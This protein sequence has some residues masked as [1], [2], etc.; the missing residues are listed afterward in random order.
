MNLLQKINFHLTKLVKMSWFN[1]RYRLYPYK[2][3][4]GIIIPVYLKY[5]Y[6]VLRFIDNNEYEQGEITIIKN[7]LHAGE[8]VLELGT[9]IGFVSAY[10]AKIAGD[11]NVSTFEGNPSMKKSI[12]KL[13]ALNKV[14]PNSTIALLGNENGSK[15]FYKNKSSFLASSAAND[16]SKKLTAFQ[17][18]EMKLNDIIQK[19]QPTYFIMDIEGGEYDIFVIIDFQSIRKVQFELHPQILGD[20]KCDEIFTVL[21]KNGFIKDALLSGGQNYY[22][23][24]EA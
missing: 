13:Y 10:C 5:G 21:N 9:G 19:L 4:E 24:R 17:V 6:S 3:I 8:K 22:Y 1:V 14:N 12:D 11:E 2:K 23:Y 7:T 18:E 15:T 20:Q 16:R